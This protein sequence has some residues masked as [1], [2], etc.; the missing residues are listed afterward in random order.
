MVAVSVSNVEASPYAKSQYET[1]C[2]KLIQ[3]K[4]AV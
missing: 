4:S 2:W 1:D 3:F